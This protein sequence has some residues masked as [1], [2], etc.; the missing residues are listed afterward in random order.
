MHCRDA[1]ADETVCGA[2]LAKNDSRPDGILLTQEFVAVDP[3]QGIKLP[4]AKSDGVHTWTEDEIAAFEARHAVGS[5]ARL[6]LALGVYTGLRRSDAVTVGPQHVRDGVLSVKQKKTGGALRIPLHTDLVE[7]ISATKNDNAMVGALAFLTTSHGKQFSDA[8]FGAWFR[9]RCDEA[10]LPAHCSFHG[11][12]KAACR[13]L[14]EAGC[15]AN[16]IA[17]ISGH[18]S[19]REVERYTRAADQ[20]RMARNALARTKLHSPT[21][22]VG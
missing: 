10:G 7:I 13:R 5:V 4:R 18:A 11:L 17:A 14:A 20:E 22:K 12:R 1:L 21:V 15:S 2:Q 19:L 16:E 9:K 3:T 6:A 8:G